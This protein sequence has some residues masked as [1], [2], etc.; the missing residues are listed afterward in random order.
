LKSKYPA[1]LKDIKD[2][3]DLAE[4]TKAK[5]TEACQEYAKNYY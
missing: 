3:G 4:D 1:V 2:K 5:L